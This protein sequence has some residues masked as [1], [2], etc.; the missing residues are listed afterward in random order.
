MR[1]RKVSFFMCGFIRLSTT[2]MGMCG[3]ILVLFVAE[4][5]HKTKQKTVEI[6]DEAAKIG[7][8]T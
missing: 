7:L 8:E 6:D 2:Y 4:V 1:V 5:K 3:F